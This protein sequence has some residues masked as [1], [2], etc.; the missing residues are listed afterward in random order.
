MEQDHFSAWIIVIALPAA[1]LKTPNG[2]ISLR[3]R[4]P[5]QRRSGCQ[6]AAVTVTAP[7]AR[8]PTPQP[9]RFAPGAAARW[10]APS[11]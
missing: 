8:H 6:E 2:G 4:M 9:L 5:L 3:K 11:L 1:V 10:M 7:T